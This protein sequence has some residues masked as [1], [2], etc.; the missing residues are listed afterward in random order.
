MPLALGSH[1]RHLA[2]LLLRALAISLV[3]LKLGCKR[4]SLDRNLE[5]DLLFALATRMEM[6]GD[7]V[8]PAINKAAAV[9]AAML[10]F[11]RAVNA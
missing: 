5:P 7:Q 2:A 3:T 9:Q 6:C 4:C 10:V 11:Y 8:A 1:W